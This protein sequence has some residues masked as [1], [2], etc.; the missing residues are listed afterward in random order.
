MNSKLMPYY[1]NKMVKNIYQP[2]YDIINAQS[3]WTDALSN[4]FTQANK[5]S[6]KLINDRMPWDNKSK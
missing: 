6:I 1:T 5:E 3:I 2:F 4:W